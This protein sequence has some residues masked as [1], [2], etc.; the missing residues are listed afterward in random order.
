MLISTIFP[1]G[2]GPSIAYILEGQVKPQKAVD[3][4]F[5]SL[6]PSESRFQ[7]PLDT[8]KHVAEK[9]HELLRSPTRSGFQQVSKVVT[10]AALLET[11]V[12]MYVDDRKARIEK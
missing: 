2:P 8:T 11:T 7:R 5:F 9:Y 1:P 3:P 4:A 12:T 6:L 10:E